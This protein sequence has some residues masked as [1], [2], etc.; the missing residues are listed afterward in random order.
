MRLIIDKTD[1]I[2]HPRFTSK[3]AC[4]WLV[5]FE[6]DENETYKVLEGVEIR[7]GVL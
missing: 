3:E 5:Q 6:S 4:Y 7:A 2:V 1:T